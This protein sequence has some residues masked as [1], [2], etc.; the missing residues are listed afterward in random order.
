M[1]AFVV[2]MTVWSSALTTSR[3]GPHIVTSQQL[4]PYS[5]PLPLP[6]DL[7]LPDPSTRH[8]VLTSGCV[9]K[10]HQAKRMEVALHGQT[11]SSP[12]GMT[13]DRRGSKVSGSDKAGPLGLSGGSNLSL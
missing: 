13:D 4:L 6:P 8:L 5:E 12:P 2:Q 1:S 7:F 9:V 3:F 11:L 10:T